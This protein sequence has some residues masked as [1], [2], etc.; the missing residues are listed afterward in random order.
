MAFK[1]L[2]E[3]FLKKV[4]GKKQTSP[5]RF[6]RK[7][8]PNPIEQIQHWRVNQNDYRRTKSPRF[9]HHGLREW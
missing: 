6:L 7:I 9:Q 5:D 2:V 3:L 8:D 1:F 4:K